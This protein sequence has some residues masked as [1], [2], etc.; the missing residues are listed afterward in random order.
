M[1]CAFCN[2]MFR[3]IGKH[4]TCS[5]TQD[6]ILHYVCGGELIQ[7]S[8]CMKN[9]AVRWANG[10]YKAIDNEIIESCKGKVCPCS[11][12]HDALLAAA[13]QAKIVSSETRI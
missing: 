3:T 8:I 5:H 9:T 6:I 1:R 2:K 11:L 12:K 10:D 13:H 4:Y 7:S